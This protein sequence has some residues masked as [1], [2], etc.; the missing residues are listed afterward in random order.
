VRRND[1]EKEQ[2]EVVYVDFGNSETLPRKALISSVSAL[3]PVP[4]CC[5]LSFA[6]AGSM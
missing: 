6:E 1:R 4:I 3:V 2:A 5:S